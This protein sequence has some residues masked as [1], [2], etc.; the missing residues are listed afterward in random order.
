MQWLDTAF[1]AIAGTALGV[2]ALTIFGWSVFHAVRLT[3]RWAKASARVVSL[4]SALAIADLPGPGGPKSTTPRG[5][6]RSAG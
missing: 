6:G 4:P 5:F 1:A 3:W 2:V